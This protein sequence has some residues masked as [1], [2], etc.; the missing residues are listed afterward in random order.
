[1]WDYVPK[2]NFHDDAVRQ[3][4]PRDVDNY[5]RWSHSWVLRDIRL[6]FLNFLT[7]D[8][9][10]GDSG[11]WVIDSV[12]GNLYGQIVAGSP[13]QSV[14]YIV[15]AK[16]IAQDVKERTGR[17]LSLPQSK[18]VPLSNAELRSKDL[19]TFDNQPWPS[20]AKVRISGIDLGR[21]N[22]LEKVFGSRPGDIITLVK[23]AKRLYKE[24]RDAGG[25]FLVLKPKLRELRITLQRFE[26]EVDEADSV[27]NRARGMY[28]KYIAPVIQDCDY[29]L[30]QLDDL[31]LNH[32][33]FTRNEGDSSPLLIKFRLLTEK[34]ELWS[35]EVDLAEQSK[36]ISATLDTYEKGKQEAKRLLDEKRVE[37]EKKRTKEKEAREAEYKKQIEH[38]LRKSGM[39]DRYIDATFKLEEDRGS[40]LGRPTYTRFSRTYLSLDTLKE[41]QIDYM[42]DMVRN[43]LSKH[44]SQANSC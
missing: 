39:P 44:D 13:G 32:W 41:F 31:L 17:D 11:S 33:S 38:F 42:L 22:V 37:E 4:V 21:A 19:L 20:A 9:D 24:C 23:F 34:T 12:T 40:D 5:T 29:T 43:N 18:P 3:I 8:T 16:H 28:A 14:A 30:R 6:L 15:P 35:L 25:E 7:D 1:V 2:P 26:K 27:L 36:K 10:Q